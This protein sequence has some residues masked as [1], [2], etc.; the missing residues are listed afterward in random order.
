MTFWSTFIMLKLVSLISWFVYVETKFS[1][2]WDG[3]WQF[4]SVTSWFTALSFPITNKLSIDSS[5]ISLAW[6]YKYELSHISLCSCWFGFWKLYWNSL[7]AFVNYKKGPKNCNKWPN[8]DHSCPIIGLI[9]YY[10]THYF[11][12]SWLGSGIIT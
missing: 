2:F 12:H 9:L 8:C 10:L 1:W 6:L 11:Y 7:G 3:V 4:S 5:A